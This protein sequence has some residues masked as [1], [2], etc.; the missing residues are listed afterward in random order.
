M[1]RPW[2]RAVLWVRFSGLRVGSRFCGWYGQSLKTRRLHRAY[3]RVVAEFTFG[4]LTGYCN[5][6]IGVQGDGELFLV[7]NEVSSYL[8]GVAGVV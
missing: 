2:E 5:D 8:D 6:L 3:D 4:T 1:R 7:Q